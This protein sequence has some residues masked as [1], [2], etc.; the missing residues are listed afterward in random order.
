M[1]HNNNYINTTWPQ[2][3]NSLVKDY[4]MLLFLD[5]PINIYVMWYVTR[6]TTLTL[7]LTLTLLKQYYATQ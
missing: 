5:S 2:A 4:T 6:T 7:H 3:L 1:Q